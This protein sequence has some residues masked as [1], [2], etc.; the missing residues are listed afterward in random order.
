M[1]VA[2]LGIPLCPLVTYVPVGVMNAALLST[3]GIIGMLSAIALV[4]PSTTFLRLGGS[5]FLSFFLS[6]FFFYIVTK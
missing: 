1:S 3:G 5:F 4:S 2:T 6:F